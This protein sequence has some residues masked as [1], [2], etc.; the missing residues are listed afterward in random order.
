[1]RRRRYIMMTKKLRDYTGKALNECTILELYNAA[2]TLTQDAC[3]D[4]GYNSG[5]KKVYYISAEFLIGKL[6]SNN[7]INLGLYDDVKNELAQAGLEITDLE[8]FEYEP[9]LGNG[10]LGRLAACFIDSLATLGLPA[11]GVGLA[12]HCGLFKQSF[13]DMK[14]HARPDYWRK[15]GMAN[16]M[17]RT[18]KH[19]KVQ[20]G[21]LELIST[22]YEI[23]VTGYGSKCGRLRLF[24]LD[25]V[26]ERLIGS[27]IDFDKKE[28]EKNLTLFL[29]PDDSDEAGRMLRVYQEYFMVSC[30]AQLILDECTERG[31]N[32][33]RHTSVSRD[34]G[35]GPSF[36]REG[37]RGR[38]SLSDRDRCL[39][40][41]QSYDP[42]R[43]AGDMAQ[44]F[45]RGRHAAPDADHQEDERCCGGKIQ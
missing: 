7:L 26:N 36:D 32:H 17:R 38:G 34:P 39:C 22:M 12:Y 16:W 9:S 6:L 30:A 41:Y 40:L 43:G 2:L 11:D 42:G 24:D 3:K 21:D 13:E 44:A 31:S 1:M 4:K 45:L 25:T 33:Q 28:I 18:D 14:Q 19:Y 29:Y 15:W 23:D 20:C 8:E 10:G 35:A 27:G 37:H 5:K